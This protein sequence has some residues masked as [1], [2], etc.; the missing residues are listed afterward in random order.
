MVAG[1]SHHLARL[2]LQ[3]VWLLLL[4]APVYGQRVSECG[5]PHERRLVR[6]VVLDDPD[7][8]D[9]LEVSGRC[10]TALIVR[11]I[12]GAGLQQLHIRDVLIHGLVGQKDPKPDAPIVPVYGIEVALDVRFDSVQFDTAVDF[13]GYHFKRS[14]AFGQQCWIPGVF[15]AQ[16]RIDGRLS[17]E[18]EYLGDFGTN[19]QPPVWTRITAIHMVGTIIDGSFVLTGHVAGNI[20]LNNLQV[21]GNATLQ[22]PLSGPEGPWIQFGQLTAQDVTIGGKIMLVGIRTVPSTSSNPEKFDFSKSGVDF[23]RLT[24]GTLE[25]RDSTFYPGIRLSFAT[26]GD[27]I[28]EGPKVTKD[29]GYETQLFDISRAR[30]ARTLSMKNG[31]LYF[32]DARGLSVAGWAQIEEVRIANA[33]LDF[34][35]FGSLWLIGVTLPQSTMTMDGVSFSELRAAASFDDIGSDRWRKPTAELPDRAKFSTSGYKN[36]EQFFQRLGLSN[37]AEEIYIHMKRRQRWE[38]FWSWSTPP[39]LVQDYVLGYGRVWTYPVLWS[40]VIV[41]LGFWLF[42][43]SVRMI[44]ISDKGPV[45]KYSPIWY[46]FELFLPL[47]KLG[48]ID[49]RR[50]NDQS[51]ALVLYWRLHQLA[52]WVLVPVALAAITGAIK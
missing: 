49:Y 1:S 48:Q 26:I 7:D 17:I 38:N 33:A 51:W 42:R 27:V 40:S 6:R 8:D 50:P 35:S 2:L 28:Y 30:I 45:P 29:A 39:D 52:G 36:L 5:T 13:V 43:N 11:G 14:L 21:R 9:Q 20:F 18:A 15:L 32:L 19:Q 44:E 34:S 3:F 12:P 16:S 31:G 10:V 37:Q 25:V 47:V 22:P 4:L 23:S 41:L 24:A 46:S